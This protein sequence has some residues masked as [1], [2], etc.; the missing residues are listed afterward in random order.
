MSEEAEKAYKKAA[1]RNKLSALL[2]CLLFLLLGGGILW[3]AVYH[4]VNAQPAQFIAYKPKAKP[5]AK[6]TK[7]QPSEENAIQD[8]IECGCCLY[9]CPANIPLL[10]IIRIAKGDVIRI[11]RGR[12]VKN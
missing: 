1:L 10:D 5:N 11:I 6:T 3:F 12:G 4:I 7:K 9:S 8:C 2:S